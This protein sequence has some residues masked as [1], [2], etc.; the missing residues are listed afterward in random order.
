M[1]TNW[2][3]VA[4]LCA[5]RTLN[6]A[7]GTPEN[8]PL[9]DSMQG[10]ALYTAYCSVCH[11]ESG[12]GDGPMAKYLRAKLP[13]LTRIAAR[14]GGSFPSAR[15]AQVIS[16]EETLPRGHGTREM[17]IWGPV[18]SQ[19]AWDRDFGPMRITNLVRRLEEMQKK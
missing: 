6:A 16:G 3:A 1:Q 15:I 9:I 17:P 2:I 10:P 12:K 4:S 18:F 13:D 19:I 7:Q 14:N 5:L 11:G 8:K